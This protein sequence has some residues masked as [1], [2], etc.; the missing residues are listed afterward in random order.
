MFNFRPQNGC[1]VGE[2]LYLF[3]HFILFFFCMLK[4]GGQKVELGDRVVYCHQ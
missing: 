3:R 2:Y 1:G 4:C